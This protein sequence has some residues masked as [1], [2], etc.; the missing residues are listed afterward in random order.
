M[1]HGVIV[2]CPYPLLKKTFYFTWEGL[3]H[4]LSAKAGSCT[5]PNELS[6]F[7]ASTFQTER[8][9]SG[10]KRRVTYYF[11]QVNGKPPKNPKCALNITAILAK[12]NQMQRGCIR[13]DRI[14]KD[15]DSTATGIGGEPPDK[16]TNQK[17][18]AD[19][20]QHANAE[21]RRYGKFRNDMT[22]YRKGETSNVYVTHVH[23]RD[24][25]P[26]C[27]RHL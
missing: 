3:N 12:T 8:P 1:R 4:D 14:I 7:V 10:Q 18:A 13:L 9:F 19:I 25:P 2:R 21:E 5:G 22:H 20:G 26:I 11:R 24:L 17:F 16:N 23:Q 15:L 27:K 6:L